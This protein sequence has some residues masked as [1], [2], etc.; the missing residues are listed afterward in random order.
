MRNIA[1]QKLKRWSAG[2][3]SS[4]IPARVPNLKKMASILKRERLAKAS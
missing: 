4:D 2:G 1:S 3:F